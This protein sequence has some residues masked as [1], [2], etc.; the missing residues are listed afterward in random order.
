MAK[1][2]QII[3]VHPRTCFFANNDEVLRRIISYLYHMQQEIGRDV[4]VCAF[5]DEKQITPEEIEAK[6][7]GEKQQCLVFSPVIGEKN[8][9]HGETCQDIKR[10]PDDR[11]NRI[12]GCQRRFFQ[13][14]IP[15]SQ[16][17]GLHACGKSADDQG[18]GDRQRDDKKTASRM[19][20]KKIGHGMLREGVMTS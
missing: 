7:E 11:E 12:R 18:T 2:A 6:L 1:L 20:A 19:A 17:I 9:P 14:R 3:S 15:Q 4:G 10:C 16:C 8:Q 13:C 5:A